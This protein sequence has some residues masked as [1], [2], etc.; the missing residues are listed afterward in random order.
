MHRNDRVQTYEAEVADLKHVYQHDI[1][2]K[3]EPR[4]SSRPFALKMCHDEI[5]ALKQKLQMTGQ[6]QTQHVIDSESGLRS[7]QQLFKKGVS[8]LHSNLD[9]GIPS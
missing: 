2:S 3:H 5:I 7:R 8:N 9:L 6:L 1:D 4:Y